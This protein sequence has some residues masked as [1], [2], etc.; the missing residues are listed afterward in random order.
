MRQIKYLIIHCSATKEGLDYRAK[1]IDRWHR[2]QGYACIG[3]HFVVDLDGTIE[4]GRDV[5]AVGAHCLGHNAESLGICYIGGLDGNGK[6]KD[7]RTEAQK[8]SMAE[9][10]RALKLQFKGSEARSHKDFANKACPC[11]DATAE[12]KNL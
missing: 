9:L 8:E 12:Y 10:V 3:Y 1:D 6:P 11:F 2:Q 4:K 7:T 5:T